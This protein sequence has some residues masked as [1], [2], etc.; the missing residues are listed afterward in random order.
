MNQGKLFDFSGNAFELTR[1]CYKILVSAGI[2]ILAA[3]IFIHQG[4]V[5]AYY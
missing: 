4:D 5:N 1:L 2:L 3:W